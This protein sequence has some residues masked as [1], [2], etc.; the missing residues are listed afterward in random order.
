MYTMDVKLPTA[1]VAAEYK[2][3]SKK[4][5]Q[6]DKFVITHGEDINRRIMKNTERI[7]RKNRVK[8]LEKFGN[9]KKKR[10]KRTAGNG[11]F[12]F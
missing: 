8:E 3:P 4:S 5:A 7:R 10:T 2:M 9:S 11:Q 1:A 6:N 12:V